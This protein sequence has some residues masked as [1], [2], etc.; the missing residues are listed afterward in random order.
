M[1]ARTLFRALMFVCCGVCPSLSA[2]TEPTA[3]E[4]TATEPAAAEV[5]VEP[6]AKAVAPIANEEALE[7]SNADSFSN[8]DPAEVEQQRRLDLYGFADLTYTKL[9]IPESN[10]WTRIYYPSNSFAVG[11]FNLYLSANLGDRWRALGEVRFMYLPNGAT[12]TDTATGE[13]KRTDTTVLDYA[14]F[15]QPIHWGAIRIERLWVEHEFSTLFKLQVGAFLTPYGIWNVD[16]GSPA[17]VGIRAPLAVVSELFPAHQTGIQ[18]Y[19]NA[20]FDPIEVGYHVTLSNGRGP[21]EYEDFDEDKA[22]GGRLYL[23]TDAVGSLTVGAS[24]YRGGYYDRSA[25]YVVS[26]GGSVVDQEYTTISKYQEFSFGTDLKWQWKHWLVQG[27][28][29][30]NDAAFETHGRPRVDALKPPQGFQPDYR[31]WGAYG[32]VGYRTHFLQTMPYAVIQ[33]VYAPNDPVVPPVLGGQV[34]LNIRPTPAVV[35][36]LEL[37]LTHFDG[38]GS[39]GLGNHPLRFLATQVAWAF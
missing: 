5:S 11:N 20:F 26:N 3:A 1:K 35:L 28:Y 16:H 30:M 27:E 32:L 15:E 10:P 13:V 12:K 29:I 8:E 6:P 34:G 25:K 33:Y 14:G 9:L 7:L 19:G 36:K 2:A 38:P 37:S 31:R 39:T 23:K 17:I 18:L 22:I 21:V 24:A 4:P